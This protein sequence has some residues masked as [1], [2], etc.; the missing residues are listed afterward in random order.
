MLAAAGDDVSIIDLLVDHGADIDAADEFHHTALTH[1]AHASAERAFEQLLR[2]GARVRDTVVLNE[3]SEHGT[4]KMIQLVL[5]EKWNRDELG[6]ALVSS[7]LNPDPGI[8]RLL[9][10]SGA[11]AN[12]PGSAY[13]PLM[14][15]A[16]QGNTAVVR[17]LLDHG[18]KVD[19][20][21]STGG[22]ALGSACEY[23]QVGIVQFL[24][25]ANSNPRLHG[26]DA[27][28]PLALAAMRGNSETL[29]V[30]LK[31]KAREDLE[32]RR[33]DGATP[34]IL[35]AWFGDTARVEVLVNAGAN[36][37]AKTDDGRTALDV[38]SSRSDAEG[39]K[40]VMFLLR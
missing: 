36:L 20:L 17:L 37:K 26:T 18:A 39:R 33:S 25:D 5:T 40:I 31:T 3:V 28:P 13:T 35:A 22:T 27:L 30:L 14:S 19:T 21:D 29:A 23:G 1:A 4:A 24:I 8:A 2:H 32:W 9:L 10:N 16:T 34:L 11:D 12:Y 38:A 15:A 7:A 6:E